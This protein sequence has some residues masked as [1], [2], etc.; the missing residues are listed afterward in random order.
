MMN[1]V[2]NVTVFHI[3]SEPLIIDYSF[4]DGQS[5]FGKQHFTMSQNRFRVQINFY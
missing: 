4:E 3:L 2:K 5:F 1:M